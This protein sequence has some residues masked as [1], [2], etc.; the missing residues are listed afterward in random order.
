MEIWASIKGYEGIYEVSSWGRVRSLDRKVTIPK[1]GTTYTIKQRGKILSLSNDR[2]GYVTV[3]LYKEG[4]AW[5]V[6]VH[7]LVAATFIPN[8]MNLEQVNHKDFDTTNNHVENLEWMS[9]KDNNRHAQQHGRGGAAKLKREVTVWRD[10]QEVGT[11]QSLHAA[12]EH[13]GCTYREILGVLKGRH[14]TARG[15]TFTSK[16]KTAL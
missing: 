7:R 16:P 11:F 9:L 1:N 6:N 12:A 15:C 4:H 14:K 8:P 13:V 2:N 10:G 3:H 5:T